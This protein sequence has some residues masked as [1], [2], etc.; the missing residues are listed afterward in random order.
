M[1]TYK[2]DPMH[3]EVHFKV[4]HLM[5]T[6][7]T[8]S[9]QKFDATMESEAADFSDAVISFTA[10]VNSISTNMEQRDEHLKSDDFFS[11]AKFP[12]LSFTSTGITKTGDDA[13]TLTGNLTIRDVTNPVSLNVTYGGTMTDFYGQTKVG[14][15]LN[16]KISRKDFGLTWNGVTEAGGIVVSDEVRLAMEI[17]MIKQ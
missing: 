15:E 17:Q 4:K 6:N 10:D 12:V 14:F 11:A 9:F 8:G 2:L 1:A 7:V 5:I 3:A 16:G 13:F